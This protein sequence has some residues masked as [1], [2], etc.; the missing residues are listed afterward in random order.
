[1]G[2]GELQAVVDREEEGKNKRMDS[3]RLCSSLNRTHAEHT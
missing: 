3:V 2:L 1:M